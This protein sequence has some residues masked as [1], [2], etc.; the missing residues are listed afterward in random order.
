[1]PILHISDGTWIDNAKI[2]V[3]LS[4]KTS[5]KVYL[6]TNTQQLMLTPTFAQNFIL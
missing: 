3:H 2:N 1:M 6:I 4:L 5:H